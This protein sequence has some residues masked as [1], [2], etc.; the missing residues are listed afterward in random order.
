MKKILFIFALLALLLSACGGNLPTPTE[1][2]TPTEKPIPSA[3]PQPTPPL[4]QL[5]NLH[6]RR[7]LN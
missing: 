7:L 2:P 3:T 1:T 6:W 4:Q 5:H